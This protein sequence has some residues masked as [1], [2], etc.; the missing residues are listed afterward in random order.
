MKLLVVCL[1]TMVL[2]FICLQPIEAHRRHLKGKKRDSS[3][4]ARKRRKRRRKTS[5]SAEEWSIDP[6]ASP[7]LPSIP[8]LRLEPLSAPTISV[9]APR[10]LLPTPSPP[11]RTPQ[12]LIVT[13]APRT[14]GVTSVPPVTA[15]LPREPPPVPTLAPDAV[16]ARPNNEEGDT[17]TPAPSLSIVKDNSNS[18]KKTATEF[19]AESS[20]STIPILICVLGGI[21]AGLGVVIVLM[22]KFNRLKNHTLYSP[23]PSFENG[24]VLSMVADPSVAS[25][26][27]LSQSSSIISS[28]GFPAYLMRETHSNN[29]QSLIRL[30]TPNSSIRWS[31]RGDPCPSVGTADT[32]NTDDDLHHR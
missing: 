17:R 14:P 21:G 16:N 3:K 13:P 19:Q 5:F 11:M 1:A 10:P 31:M 32:H 26:G 4:K 23:S 7:P 30:H 22:K 15:A 18:R 29:L 27:T 12:P 2:L 28:E 8:P 9:P 24:K 25:C 6:P 20:K